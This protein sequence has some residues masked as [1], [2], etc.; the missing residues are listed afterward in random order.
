MIG[1]PFPLVSILMPA[2]NAAATIE[3]AIASL[4]AQSYQNW[5]CIIVDDGSTDNTIEIINK[6]IEKRVKIYKLEKNY[7]RGVARKKSLAMAN[8]K[9]ITMLDADDW[10]YPDKIFKQ[11]KF[12]EDN[13]DVCLHSM[14]MA[15][16]SNG[17]LHSV[18]RSDQLVVDRLRVLKKTSIAHA[19][20]MIRRSCIGEKT[21]NKNLKFS[22]DQDFIR[23][24]LIDK[25]YVI[26]PEVGYCYTEFESVGIAKIVK[27]YFYSSI[28]FFKNRSIF[29]Y[30]SILYSFLEL[31]KIPYILIL[32]FIRGQRYLISS[33]SK[34]PS[35]NDV[36]CYRNAVALI[37]NFS[38]L[39][40]K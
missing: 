14:G 31:M 19:P 37:N 2:Y 22:Q 39:N 8:G 35:E 24:V 27:S 3:L 7:G 13:P 1:H 17:E 11:V 6:I 32:Y 4:T 38:S 20:S 34:T 12:L 26:S 28:S 5:E 23:R 36:L 10:L 9:Y 33:R 29:G 40:K 18:R 30:K 21:Y 16:V 25:K 15:I